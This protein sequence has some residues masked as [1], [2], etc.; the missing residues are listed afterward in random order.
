MSRGAGVTVPAFG[1]DYR[2]KVTEWA[3]GQVG[4]NDPQPYWMSARG[5]RI[6]YP[7]HWCG[8]FALTALHEAGLA[9][10]THWVIGSGFLWQLK[11]TRDPLPGDVAYFKRFQHHAIVGDVEVDGALVE[12]VNGNSRPLV[13]GR[14]S[15]QLSRVLTHGPGAPDAYYSIERLIDDARRD[16]LRSGNADPPR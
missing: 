11:M 15:V 13:E 4:R 16:V 9:T 1:A 10:G 14:T 12:L 7:R 2:L 8:A 5:S 3:Y 6:P